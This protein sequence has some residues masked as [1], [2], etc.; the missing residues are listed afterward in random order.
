MIRSRLLALL[1]A[2]SCLGSPLPAQEP[3]STAAPGLDECVLTWRPI[4][5]DTRSV[6]NRDV[7]GAHV[8][9]LSG[10]YLWTCG[11]AT[12]QADSAV[13][14]DGPRQVELFGNVVYRDT[15]R[16]LKS[17]RLLYFQLS[18]F[19][20]AEQNVELLRLTDSS[21]LA[22]P[23]VEFL[24]AVS[25]LDAFTTAPGRPTVTFYPTSGESREPFVVESDVAIFAGEDEARF[26]G[27]A[28]ITRS[29]MNARADSAY[30]TRTEGSGVMWGD[31][32]IEAEQIRLE[33][34]T[35][36]FRSENEELE[37]VHATGDAYAS[38][39]RFE[40]RA[41][42]IDIALENREV[43]AV[44]AHGEG[45]GEAASGAHLV[46]GDSLYFAM[47]G[48]QIDTLYAVGNAIAIQ[49]DSTAATEGS[50]EDETPG[51]GEE[52]A[53][54]SMEVRADSLASPAATDSAAASPDSAAVAAP[55]L[56]TD[57]SMN[58][59]KGDTLIAA[60][61]RPA[62]AV[63][64]TAAAPAPLMSKLDLIGN[65]SALYRMVRDS[66]ASSRPSL[67]YMI[68]ARIEVGFRDGGPHTVAGDHA[69]GVYLEPREVFGLE[70]AAD[71]S[72]T[73]ADTLSGAAPA[74]S[75]GTPS[76]TL[77][78]PPDTSF[79]PPDTS[80]APPDTLRRR[81]RP[82]TPGHVAAP[83]RIPPAGWLGPLRT[84]AGQR[85]RRVR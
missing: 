11:S 3:D 79:A 80:S 9:H 60:F 5:S 63:S 32:W 54:D 59:A 2:A 13:K 15:I 10:R 7:S 42:V 68:G 53:G 62:E 45:V 34:D 44:W 25:G 31:P 38:G 65:A 33:G 73:A 23:R 71:S 75:A 69:I 14:R 6:T 81:G 20:I 64:D 17:D 78:V 49:Q 41:E 8:T 67:N 48:S 47:Y 35:I 46:Y 58:W 85:S 37:E 24:R 18:D 36:R 43:K 55:E 12:M 26:H 72:G 4:E 22:G 57:G 19:V 30:L 40:V 82:G 28:V 74:D 61:E 76:D 50:T 21:T 77:S 83:V 51:A 70:P 84:P 56:A 27:D 16:T 29:D 1:V 52:A 66:T 39:D